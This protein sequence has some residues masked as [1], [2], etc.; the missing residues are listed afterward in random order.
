MLVY[1]IRTPNGRIWLDRI[2]V[3]VPGMGIIIRNLYLARI[4]KS[5]ATLMKSGIPILDALRITADLVDNNVFRNIVLDAEENVRGGGSI[6]GALIKYKEIPPLFSSMMSIGERTGKMD[7]IL[8]HISKFYKTESENSIEG[9][10]QIIEPVLILVLG[11]GVAVLV[12]SILLPIYSV[13][14]GA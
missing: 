10:S 11:V 8:E 4:A 7:F 3:S 2:E 13:V 5:L 6:S 12:S 14:S 9:I 1:Y